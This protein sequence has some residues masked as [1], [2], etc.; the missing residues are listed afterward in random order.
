MPASV[1]AALYKDSL[2]ITEQG[3]KEKPV[4]Q[5]TDKIVNMV[6]ETP[7]PVPK[8][9]L[10]D[11][12]KKIVIL[13]NDTSAVHIN[14]EYLGTLSKLLTACKLTLAD[15]AIVNLA[16]QPKVFR[17]IRD[18]LHAAY[19]LMFNVSTQDIQLPF[20]IPHYQVQQYSGCVF[21]TAPIITLSGQTTDA[22]RTEKRSLWEKMKVLFGV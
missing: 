15:V 20:T 16:Q 9:F 10:G 7:P 5:F 4:P 2:V 12:L 21:M 19:V 8:W 3:L 14:D 22:V 6:T 17:D 18:E 1:I 11:N 13:V